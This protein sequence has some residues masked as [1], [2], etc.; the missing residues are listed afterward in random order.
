M[1]MEDQILQLKVRNDS[2]AVVFVYEKRYEKTESDNAQYK[3]WHEVVTA[4][5]VN[6]GY[7]HE[8]SDEGKYELVKSVADALADIY[9]YET[10]TYEMGVSFYINHRTYING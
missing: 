1:M 2:D 7:D 8:L 10:D 6:F 4:V 9:S 5:P 3:H